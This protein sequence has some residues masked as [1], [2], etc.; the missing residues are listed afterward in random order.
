MTSNTNIQYNTRQDIARHVETR[1]D[2]TTQDDIRQ[3]M[4]IQD[5][6]TQGKA[7]QERTR[8]DRARDKTRHDKARHDNTTHDKT[9]RTSKILISRIIISSSLRRDEGTRG[10]EHDK[11]REEKR[12]R[13]QGNSTQ[14]KTRNEKRRQD[15][16]LVFA[17]ASVLVLPYLCTCFFSKTLQSN[18]FAS[19][20]WCL[21]WVV[22]SFV[23]MC[24]CLRV[25]SRVFVPHCF[26][27]MLNT[28]QF[29]LLSLFILRFGFS[30]SL[31]VSLCWVCV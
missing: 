24:R 18:G 2:K 8:Q 27:R 23:F 16:V 5:K 31:A 29:C 20:P 19:L 17:F 1:Q 4:T 15:C 10:E 3:H 9:D 25:P 30:L 13:R 11:R 12:R 6:T 7:G 14:H 28:Q 21:H 22:L 26:L